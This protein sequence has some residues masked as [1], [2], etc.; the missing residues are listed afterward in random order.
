METVRDILEAHHSG[1]SKPGLLAWAQLR[2]DTRMTEARLDEELALLGDEVVDVDGFL[3]LRRNLEFA[4]RGSSKPATPAM[5]M[6]GA[7]RVAPN[8]TAAQPARPATRPGRALPARPAFRLP[9]LR[10]L[11]GLG[12][13]I[14]WILGFNGF[15]FGSSTAT[16]MPTVET[17]APTPVEGTVIGVSEMANGDCVLLPTESQFSEI[18]RVP[19]TT[20]HDGEVI[21]IGDH[22]EGAFPGRQGFS[23]FVD[24]KCMP[25][26]ETWTGSS[27]DAQAILE[28]GWFTP[29][30]D[31]WTA[32]S[33]G[34]ECYVT[35]S[36]GS[37]SSRSYLN[38][39]P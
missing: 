4:R 39:R 25:A 24:A 6:P 3:Y 10:G 29:T 13:F 37:L 32:G 18:R 21:F 22:P 35:R 31:A 38:A 34:V 12:F 33:R 9:D 15:P 2:I 14:V 1:I 5:S 27:V 19:C 30:E 26:F 23:T 16:P 28:I 8:T 7:V 36:D 20:P 17:A 11:A